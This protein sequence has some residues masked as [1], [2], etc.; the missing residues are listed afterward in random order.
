MKRSIELRNIFLDNCRS[1]DRGTV[2]SMLASSIRSFREFSE[3]VSRH[4]GGIEASS[5]C[6][7]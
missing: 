5:P 6:K 7:G 1:A 4:T 2:V 3:S